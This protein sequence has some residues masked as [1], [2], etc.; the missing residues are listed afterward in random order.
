MKLLCIP[1]NFQKNLYNLRSMTGLSQAELGEMVGYGQNHV[2]YWE[3]GKAFPGIE[4]LIRL[5]ACFDV[6]LDSLLYYP[7]TAKG[8][9]N[10]VCLNY[11]K[12]MRVE[13]HIDSGEMV[14]WRMIESKLV[15]IMEILDPSLRKRYLEILKKFVEDIHRLAVIEIVDSQTP[16][17]G[18]FPK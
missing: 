13:R 12:I 11:K 9:C 7:N 14:E 6:T 1:E 10:T 16:D 2:S 8:R 5:S 17:I 18:E 4:A 15:E 3:H